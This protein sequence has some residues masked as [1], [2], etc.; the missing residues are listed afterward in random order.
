ML[1]RNSIKSFAN[2]IVVNLCSIK[3]N[4]SGAVLRNQPLMRLIQNMLRDCPLKLKKKHSPSPNQAGG[5]SFMAG[6]AH[7]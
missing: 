1:N 6:M 3:L 2:S 7:N 5:G 4:V